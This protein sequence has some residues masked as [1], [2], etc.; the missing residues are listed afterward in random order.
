MS[1]FDIAD[2]LHPNF[3][4]FRS[5]ICK[6][7]RPFGGCDG[8]LGAARPTGSSWCRCLRCLCVTWVRLAARRNCPKHARVNTTISSSILAAF[9][10]LFMGCGAAETETSHP[11]TDNRND[12]PAQSSQ[13]TGAD[14]DG[15]ETAICGGL[16]GLACSDALV[17][18]FPIEAHCGAA[19]Q[20]GT[21]QEKPEMCTQIYQPVCGCD[22]Q[23]YGN[24]CT[25]HQ[26]GTSVA[27]EGECQSAGDAQLETPT[28]DSSTATRACGSRGLAP[29]G[30]DEFCDFPIDAQCGAADRPGT[31]QPRPAACTRE[32]R[33]VC[34]CDG[35]T[36]P[37]RCVAASQGVGVMHEGPC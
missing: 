4:C 26:A 8:E 32:F 6:A 3:S 9:S 12:E 13:D 23:T 29:C 37:T 25:A 27:S 33:P 1:N 36:H 21:C 18:I 2:L 19:D 34:G 20:T 15:S 7:R 10:A 28:P 17:C 24:E 14:G 30:A 16:A 22:G 11:A 5:H 35:Q 31:C